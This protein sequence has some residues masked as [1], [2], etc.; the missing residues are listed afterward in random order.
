MLGF[1]MVSVKKAHFVLFVRSLTTVIASIEGLLFF[2]SRRIGFPSIQ[3]DIPQN[4]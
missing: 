3:N 2:M 4:L 1:Q